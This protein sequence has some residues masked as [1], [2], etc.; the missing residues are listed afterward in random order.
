[1]QIF[2]T[3]TQGA[4][5]GLKVQRVT[6]EGVNGAAAT[7]TP[8][9]V[10]QLDIAQTAIGLAANT[11]Q[12]GAERSI[13][14]VWKLPATAGGANKH[15]VFAIYLGRM[16]ESPLGGTKTCATG[17]RGRFLLQGITNAWVE[18]NNANVIAGAPLTAQKLASQD[19]HTLQ[20]DLANWTTQGVEYLGWLLEAVAASAAGTP[21]LALT[22]FVGEGRGTYSTGTTG[23]TN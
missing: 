11:T 10:V 16:S 13:L 23:G 20:T 12:E 15:G 8:G 2:E 7:L 21:V 3:S 22:L 9:M 18:N 6:C 19:D 1:M 4:F 17:L 14:S 5:L